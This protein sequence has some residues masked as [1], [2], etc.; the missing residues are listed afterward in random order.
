[1]GFSLIIVRIRKIL[2]YWIPVFETKYSVEIN[3]DLETKS[4]FYSVTAVNSSTVPLH[5]QF[6]V[7]SKKIL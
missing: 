7:Q 1:M 3:Y 6:L 5:F 2:G 4:G